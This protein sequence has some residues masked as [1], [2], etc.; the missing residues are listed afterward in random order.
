MFKTKRLYPKTRHTKHLALVTIMSITLW[1]TELYAASNQHENI[2]FEGHAY[3]I[4]KRILLYTEHHS[5]SLNSQ[6][7]Y[8]T[9]KVTY[10]TPKG[11]VFAKKELDFSDNQLVPELSFNDSR[12]QQT[13]LLTSTPSEIKIEKVQYNDI[14]KHS[15]NYDTDKLI[16]ADA[17]FDRLVIKSWNDL[18]NKKTIKFQVLTMDRADLI[19]FRLNV[20]E[21]TNKKLHLSISPSNWLIRLL[22]NPN[23]LEYDLSSKRLLKF[24]GLTNISEFINGQ[25]Q[26]NNYVASIEYRYF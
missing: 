5:I 6:G 26:E 1:N 13:T 14:K 9:G 25:D 22:M 8:Q 11:E 18:L 21:I 24:S 3:S 19:K 10:K 15:I 16:V 2:H 20:N 7:Q 4:D 23:Q 17:G 12:S